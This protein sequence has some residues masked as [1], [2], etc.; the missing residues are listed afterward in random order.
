MFQP[1]MLMP[2]HGQVIDN[3]EEKIEAYTKRVKKR[4]S[5]ILGLI[6]QGVGTAEELVDRLYDGVVLILGKGIAETT[7]RAHVLKLINDGKVE[8]DR[9]GRLILRKK[10]R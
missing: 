9:D 6:N 10:V 2:G 1:K 7:V 5:N 8:T 4:E 3:P